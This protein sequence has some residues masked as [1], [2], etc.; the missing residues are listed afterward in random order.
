MK[1][2]IILLLTILSLSD[3]YAVLKERNL[4]Q[5]LNVL[6]AELT[7]R[8]Q[9]LSSQAEQRKQQTKDIIQQ[10]R[11]TIKRSNQNALMLYSQQ[12]N[13]VFDL[14]YA[15]HEATEQY[16]SFQRQQLP[17]KTY[18]ETLDVEIAKY[19]SLVTSLKHIRP[20]LLDDQA[21]TNRTVC[22]T[23]ATSIRNTLHDTR[24]QVTEYITFY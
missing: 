3:A 8:Y 5:T 12:N 10:L 11:E 4:E 9:E 6:R 17:F 13:Y 19:D 20:A 22:L 2:I 14:T 18:I 15:C 24:E 23:L 7:E 1:R 21:K 16:L